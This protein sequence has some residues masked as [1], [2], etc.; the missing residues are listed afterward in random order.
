MTNKEK[1]IEV[2]GNCIDYDFSD[3]CA[4]FNCPEKEE[5]EGHCSDCFDCPAY[6]FWENE[7]KDPNKV[8]LG[9]VVKDSNGLCGVVIEKSMGEINITLKDREIVNNDDYFVLAIMPS[10]CLCIHE[11]TK[12]YI[13]ENR[14]GECVD[15][16]PIKDILMALIKI[17]EAK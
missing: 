14:T 12:E 17:R 13:I 5:L 8:S 10:G 9:E 15:V 3:N 16:K 11:L 1:F 4:G 7:Y 6:N 2:F